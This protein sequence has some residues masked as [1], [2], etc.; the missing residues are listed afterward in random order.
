MQTFIQVH[1]YTTTWLQVSN[2]SNIIIIISAS[3]MLPSPKLLILN[4]IGWVCLWGESNRSCRCNAVACWLKWLGVV[5]LYENS[6]LL[7]TA[8]HNLLWIVLLTSRSSS[9]RIRNHSLLNLQL[10]CHL[11]RWRLMWILQGILR[12]HSLLHHLVRHLHSIWRSM[13]SILQGKVNYLIP[14]CDVFCSAP[15]AYDYTESMM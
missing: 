2:I 7:I 15:L 6:P 9:L 1:D 10:V 3:S 4:P 14:S 11:R 8:H 12:N 13:L 5:A